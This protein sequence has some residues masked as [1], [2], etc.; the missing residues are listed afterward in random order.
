M[1]ADLREVRT[2]QHHPTAK[3]DGTELHWFAMLQRTLPARYRAD[4]ASLIHADGNRSQQHDIVIH[5]RQFR[6]V[7]PRYG[8]RPADEP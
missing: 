7:L 4:R 1:Q 6:P 5:D 2:V 3:G 8:W